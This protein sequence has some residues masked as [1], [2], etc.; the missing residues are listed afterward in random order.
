MKTAI[1]IS[2]N[3][4]TISETSDSARMTQVPFKG[5]CLYFADYLAWKGHRWPKLPYRLQFLKVVLRVLTPICCIIYSNS[6]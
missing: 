6:S 1:A 4:V 5:A 2:E 3:Y